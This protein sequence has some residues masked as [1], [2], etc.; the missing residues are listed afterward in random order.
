MARAALVACLV[1][2]PGGHGPARRRVVHQ[3]RPD[4]CRAERCRR[5]GVRRR[6]SLLPAHRHLGAH[7]QRVRAGCRVPAAVRRDP[8]RRGR[9]SER[10]AQARAAAPHVRS[11]A[12]RGQGAGGV[13][14]DRRHGAPALPGALRAAAA[15]VHA[16][17]AGA[18]PARA[19]LGSGD[20]PGAVRGAHRRDV[21]TGRRGAAGPG[22]GRARGPCR[23]R[24]GQ[25]AGRAGLQQH[26]AGAPARLAGGHAERAHQQCDGHARGVA[27]ALQCSP[28]AS[29]PGARGDPPRRRR[30]NRTARRPG[31]SR[32][33]S[34][35]PGS[36]A[37]R[38]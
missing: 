19:E 15:G 24:G 22:P 18:Q 2:V 35:C 36:G 37:G 8:C 13:L 4:V 29:S 3:R 26:A 34:R 16:G 5:H 1:G 14:A 33:R 10:R 21:P 28:T 20:V 17:G 38:A 23:G 12:R 30:G 27:V 32:P 31:G 25:P 11:G 7:V 9:S 6:R